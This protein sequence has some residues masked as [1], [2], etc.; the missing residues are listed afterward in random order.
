MNT[1]KWAAKN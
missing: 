1:Q